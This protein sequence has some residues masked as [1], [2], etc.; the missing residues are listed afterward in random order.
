MAAFI[1]SVLIDAEPEQQRKSMLAGIVPVCLELATLEALP[2]NV[3][4]GMYRTALYDTG[5]V[6]RLVINNW[7][8]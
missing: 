8:N 3:E 4:Q 2:Y 7:N 5:Q 1:L 6:Y